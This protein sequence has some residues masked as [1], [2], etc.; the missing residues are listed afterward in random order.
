[1]SLLSGAESV[2]WSRC[3]AGCGPC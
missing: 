2:S 1:M 3:A